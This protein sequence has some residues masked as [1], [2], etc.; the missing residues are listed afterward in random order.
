MFHWLKQLL[1]PHTG[2]TLTRRDRETGR[3]YTECVKCGKQSPGV[4]MGKAALRCGNDGPAFRYNLQRGRNPRAW[5][6]V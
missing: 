5:V 6:K 3:M 2:D 4:V 1:C